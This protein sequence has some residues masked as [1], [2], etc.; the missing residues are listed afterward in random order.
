MSS[1]VKSLDPNH[2]VSLGTIGSGQCGAAGGAY[3]DVH[4][5]PGIDLCEYHDYS[6]DAMPGDQWNGLAVR[7]L[8]CSGLGKP[9]FVGETGIK[10][11]LVGT[12][13]ARADLL[14]AKLAAQL[15]AGTAGVLA[16]DWRDEAHGGSSLAGYEIGP[17]DPALAVLSNH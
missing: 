6:T 13:A 3:Q 9:L 11:S 16:W 10:T 17:S 1:L 7:L 4:G 15:G 8:Q 12:L 14:D 2:L 5:V